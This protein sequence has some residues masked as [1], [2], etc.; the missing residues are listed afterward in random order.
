MKNVNLTPQSNGT[1]TIA[2]LAHVSVHSAASIPWQTTSIRVDPEQWKQVKMRAL[3]ENTTVQ[4]IV[5]QALEY[6]LN[7]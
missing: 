2:Q 6:W 3:E 1:K 7:H 5:H 4:E